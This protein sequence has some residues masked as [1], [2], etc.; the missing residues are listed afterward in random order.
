MAKFLS[1]VHPCMSNPNML[2]PHLAWASVAC[3]E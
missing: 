1:F 3:D 2:H